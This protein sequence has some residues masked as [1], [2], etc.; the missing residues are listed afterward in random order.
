MNLTLL[1]PVVFSNLKVND[2]LVNLQGYTAVVTYVA[3]NFA[4]IRYENGFECAP[5]P[6]YLELEF[7]LQPLCWVEGKP[8]YPG[9]G[10]LYFKY[11]PAW[12]HNEEGVTASSIRDDE[13]Y[14]YGGIAFPIAD[15]TWTKP[16]LKRV[17]SFQVE[18]VDVFPGD[19]VYYYGINKREWGAEHTVK[20]NNSVVWKR[21]GRTADVNGFDRGS[22]AFRLKPMLV[23]GDHLVPMPVRNAAEMKNGDY[24]YTPCLYSSTGYLKYV[25]SNHSFDIEMYDM[26]LVHLNNEA[27]SAHTE[28]FLAL[29][30]K[31]D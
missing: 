21:T 9:D 10:P 16:Q 25:W 8:V 14:F 12:K 22:A 11:D 18:G 24:Y 2:K 30:K 19:T 1:H 27:A 29:S 17:P 3:Q 13:L 6:A 7:R 26:G 4:V 23:I 31:K 20:E 5:Y 28:A 15:A